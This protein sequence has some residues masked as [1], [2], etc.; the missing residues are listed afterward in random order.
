MLHSADPKKLNK[1]ECP[2]KEARIS[3]RRGGGQFSHRRQMEG[4]N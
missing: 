3:L 4:G 1:K 2:G